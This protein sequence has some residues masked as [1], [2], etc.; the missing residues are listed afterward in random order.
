MTT[1]SH[2]LVQVSGVLCI[3]NSLTNLGLALCIQPQITGTEGLCQASCS[4]QPRRRKQAVLSIHVKM[5]QA[6]TETEEKRTP[7]L[8]P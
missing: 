5:T 8:S 2:G 3:L 4:W 7:S 1:A 6:V